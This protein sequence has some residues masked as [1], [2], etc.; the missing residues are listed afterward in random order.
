MNSTAPAT[1]DH[2]PPHAALALRVEGL[3]FAWPGQPSCLD[4]P[5]LDIAAGDTVFLH[6]PS[7]S[8]KSTLLSLLA[9]ITVAQAGAVVLGGQDLGALPARRRDGFRADH[10]G[11]VFQQFNL[12]PYLSARDNVLLPCRFSVL[13][14]RQARL[15]GASIGEEAAR[16]LLRL[17]VAEHLHDR[18]AATLSVGEQQRVAAARALIGRPTLLIADEPTSALD[19]RNSHHFL[20]LVLSEC[21]GSCALL[22]VSHD[23]RLASRFG[24]SVA[25]ADLNHMIPG[26]RQ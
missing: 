19:E 16:L 18:P 1:I 20:D 21:A 2:A 12:V 6:G 23:R 11:I 25:M 22:M 15:G 14:T 26:A 8:G 13:R 24:R 5:R 17:G 4:V 10:I 3:R 7:G 9:G